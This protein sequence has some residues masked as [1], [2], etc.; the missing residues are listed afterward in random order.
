MS[1]HADLTVV[2]HKSA[3]E[4]HVQGLRRTPRN[5]AR[6]RVGAAEQFSSLVQLVE[7]AILGH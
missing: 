4:L 5:L 1:D 2:P 6:N 7:N 3:L